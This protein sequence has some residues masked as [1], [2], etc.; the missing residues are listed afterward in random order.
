MTRRALLC[1]LPALTACTKTLGPIPRSDTVPT[2][3]KSDEQWFAQ[4]TPQQFYVTRKGATDEPF[5][6]TMH[7]SHAQGESHCICCDLLLFDAKDKYDSGTGWPAFKRPV[8]LENL[9]S[10]VGDTLK[11]GIEVRCARCDAH[12]G[13]IFDDGPSPD[14]LRYCINESALKFV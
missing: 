2:L 6:G 4:L 1:L 13:H 10:H 8:A 11:G 5:T 12:L 14:Y 9:R 3:R 7:T